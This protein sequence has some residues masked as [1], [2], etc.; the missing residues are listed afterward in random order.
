MN[1]WKNSSPLSIVYYRL[2]ALWVLNE[3]LLGGIIHG[4]KIPV[5]GLFVGSC[6]VLCICL[7]AW[8]VPARGAIFRA[9]LVVAIFKMML[10][11]QAPFTAYIAVL[12]Q[13]AMGE[14]LFLNRRWYRFSSVLLALLALVESG[15]QR[16]ITLTIIYGKSFWTAVDSFLNGLTGQAGHTSYSLLLAAAYLALHVLA[17]LITGWMA[18]GLPR[19]IERWRSDTDNRI[20][21]PATVENDIHSSTKKR[22]VIRT[23]L[24]IIW[25]VLLAL[26]LQ[27]N[28]GIGKPLLPSKLVAGILTRSA[29]IVLGWIFVIG[30]LLNQLLRYWLEKKKSGLREEI[31][32]VLALLPQTRQLVAEAWK[33]SAVRKG[34]P[35]WRQF[36]KLVLF[37]ALEPV[38]DQSVVILTGPVQTGKTT[39]LLQWADQRNDVAGVLSPVVEGKR[40]FVDLHN[41]HLFPMEVVAGAGDELPVGKFLFSREAFAKAE[42]L[43]RRHWGKTGWLVIDEIGPLELRGEGFH[44]L[45]SEILKMERENQR[46]LLV[47]REGMVDEVVRFFKLSEAVVIRSLQAIGA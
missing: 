44:G 12:F 17:G 29:L 38:S 39:S 28:L 16:I 2:I 36:G 45:L 8:Y 10:S 30:P 40:M 35:R 46:L 47:V 37:N 6:A 27:S 34:V 22:R 21:L 43:I 1:A 25:I 20:I 5:S 19:R 13:G 31:K 9:T 15:F 42:N 14:L 41:R 7:I 33:R 23:S 24:L 26:Y 4:L 32:Q 18:A 3:A 11:P